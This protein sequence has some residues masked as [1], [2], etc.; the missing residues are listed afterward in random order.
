MSG[1]VDM[2]T[3][4]V[5]SRNKTDKDEAIVDT[6]KGSSELVREKCISL[7]SKFNKSMSCSEASVAMIVDC[8]SP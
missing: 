8:V 3:N 4:E 7:L 2:W 1:L 5:Q 6:R